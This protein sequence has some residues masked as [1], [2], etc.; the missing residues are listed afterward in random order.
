MNKSLAL[1]LVLIAI[2]LCSCNNEKP[3]ASFTVS[4]SSGCYPLNVTF[5]AGNSQDPDG[6]ISSYSWDFGDSQSGRGVSVNHIYNTQGVFTATLTITD[7]SDAISVSSLTI[8]LNSIDGQ[9]RGTAV[10]NVAR[11]GESLTYLTMLLNQISTDPSIVTGTAVWDHIPGV[12]YMGNGTLDTAN[13]ILTITWSSPGFNNFTVTGNYTD[14]C[15]SFSGT[16]NGSSYTE[17]P[18]TMVWQSL[19]PENLK[20][21]NLN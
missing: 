7:D 18:F 10:K 15:R 14:D 17:N 19:I 2:I 21:L 5:N 4:K 3:I 12:Y 9:W 6:D 13:N 11:K 1:F 20:I 16:I 8:T